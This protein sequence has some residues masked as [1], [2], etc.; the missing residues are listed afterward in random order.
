MHGG[1]AKGG[2]QKMVD[3]AIAGKA[4]KKKEEER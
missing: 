3:D 2:A 4:A 1:T